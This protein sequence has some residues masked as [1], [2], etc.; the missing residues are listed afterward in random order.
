MATLSS[1]FH[2]FI[3][4]DAENFTTSEELSI[5]ELAGVYAQFARDG[6]RVNTKS[7][8][9]HN[10]CA[11]FLDGLNRTATKLRLGTA[12]RKYRTAFT[13]NYRAL[14]PDEQRHYR[15][16]VLRASIDQCAAI[17][18]NGDTFEF[19]PD[20]IRLARGLQSSW[21][22]V[23]SLLER[24]EQSLDASRRKF[25]PARS[26]MHMSMITLDR[27]WASF[28]H[29]YIAELIGIEEKARK[30]L[31]AAVDYEG[32][33]SEIESMFE[34]KKEGLYSCPAYT[35]VRQDFITC[36]A[37]LNS[38]A[39]IR[40][41]GRD[42]MTDAV[43]VKAIAVLQQCKTKKDP[44]SEVAINL[45][46]D[47]VESFD[48][49]RH[50]VRQ[51][52]ECLECV[53]PNLCKNAGLVARLVDWEESWE[54]GSQYVQKEE[55]LKSV[56]NLVAKVQKA[57]HLVPALTA[58]CEDCDVELFLVLPRMV[59]L[60]YLAEPNQ[61]QG[62]VASL[63]PHR[64]EKGADTELFAFVESFQRVV[65]SISKVVGVEQAENTLVQRAVLGS[66]SVKAH[67]PRAEIENFMLELE[68]WS[69][70]LQRKCPEDWNQCSSVLIQ[71]LTGGSQKDRTGEFS[72]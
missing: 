34:R 29:K 69:M 57:Q 44:V 15:V 2:K 59:W 21:A 11:A 35:R 23:G 8:H 37:R 6:G 70:E 24:W 58:M 67:M 28:E 25:R 52:G 9:W 7:D 36:L 64:F 27:A 56:C 51:V 54:V 22:E 17:W 66:S 42:D 46:S 19:S 26:E 65:G 53:D 5:N 1:A 63:L 68:R 62:L 60:C 32:K 55:L 12:P 45:A 3:G 48:A 49:I 20:V 41:K 13:V 14:F 18:V 61:H 33:M 72:V 43:L 71:C 38:V 10:S 40:R 30:Y 39:N 4:M 50:Y 16:D 47:V 31:V